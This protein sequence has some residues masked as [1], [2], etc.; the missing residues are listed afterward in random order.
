M[1]LRDGAK[2]KKKTVLAP[3]VKYDK[4][5]SD[6][7]KKILWLLQKIYNNHP[8]NA[9]PLLIVLKD[10]TNT[11]YNLYIQLIITYRKM[12]VNKILCRMLFSTGQQI[13]TR[14]PKAPKLLPGELEP[15]RFDQ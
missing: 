15:F 8:A 5:E 9:A 7:I 12:L 14:S 10:C 4:I 6:N 3:A 13:T 2:Q 1:K 11:L